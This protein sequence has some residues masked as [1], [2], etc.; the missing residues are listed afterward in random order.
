MWLAAPDAVHASHC[1]L[2]TA[3]VDVPAGTL[4]VTVS[5]RGWSL[6]WVTLS[7]KGSQGLR[8]DA[9]GPL[10]RQMVQEALPLCHSQGFMLSDAPDQLRWLL[11]SLALEQGYDLVCTTGG[12]GVAPRDFAPQVT[13]F[14]LD[15]QLP[16][17]SQAMMAASLAKT[18]NASISRA[19]A[20]VLGST[21]VVNLPGS[22][23]AVQ[24]N[25]E[26]ILPAIGH[27]LAKLNGDTADCG[28]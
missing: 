15:M 14:L 8:R 6:A 7:D 24:E 28:G 18:P 3:L 2:L 11:T 19:V 4:D 23:K 5:K 16:G 20:G 12:T 26:A 13:A 1:P 21:L 10:I 9:S 17:F 22:R 25:L 27:A